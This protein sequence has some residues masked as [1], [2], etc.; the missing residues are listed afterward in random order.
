MFTY[1]N[2]HSIKN[3]NSNSIMIE[4]LSQFIKYIKYIKIYKKRIFFYTNKIKKKLSKL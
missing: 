3:I 2:V 4:G 1:N